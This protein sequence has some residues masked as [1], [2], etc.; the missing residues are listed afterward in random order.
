MTRPRIAAATPF[1]ILFFVCTVLFTAQA[2][3]VRAQQSDKETAE[4]HL[5]VAERS[6]NEGA[7]AVAL[8]KARAAFNLHPTHARALF[9]ESEALIDLYAQ[10]YFSVSRSSIADRILEIEHVTKGMHMFLTLNPDFP[11]LEIWRDQLT[12]LNSYLTYG[13]DA[14]T[15][16]LL[17]KDIRS[18]NP[19]VIGE[20][21]TESKDRKTGTITLRAIFASD[22]KG[23]HVVVVEGLQRSDLIRKALEAARQIKFTP[24]TKD[25]RPV[26]MAMQLEYNFS[27]N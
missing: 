14:K 27:L 10:E 15:R 1:V 4:E 5:K 13:R 6:L 3:A 12:V 22:G 19:Q 2:I 23:K 9:V 8:A 21:K 20:T 25:G 17:T 16:Q 7:Y 26:S 11:D 18:L 24:A